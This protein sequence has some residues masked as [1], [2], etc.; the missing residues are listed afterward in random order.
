MVTYIGSEI[1]LYGTKRTARY[2]HLE[3]GKRGSA[4]PSQHAPHVGAGRADKMYPFRE[5][6]R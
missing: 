1:K 5:K 4:L 3:T 2:S 6:G